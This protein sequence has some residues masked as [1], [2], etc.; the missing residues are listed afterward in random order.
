MVAEVLVEALEGLK[1]QV[2][3]PDEDLSGVVIE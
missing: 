3:E 2:P 1:I